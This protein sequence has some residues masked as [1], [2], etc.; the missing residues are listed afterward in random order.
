MAYT[1]TNFIS[2]VE[3]RT[4]LPTNQLTWTEGEILAVADEEA[5]S[6]IIPSILSVREEYYVMTKEYQVTAGQASYRMPPRG[7][8]LIS[9]EIQ[10]RD[11]SGN[12]T[13]LPRIMPEDVE[14]NQQGPVTGFYLKGNYIVLD[15]IPSTTSG[16]LKVDFFIRPGDLVL[17]ASAAVISDINTGTGQVT[18]TTIPNAWA[19]G[20]IF[21]FISYDGGHEYVDIDYTSTDITSNVITFASLPSTLRV[22]DYLALQGQSPLIQLPPE[23]QPAFAQQVAAVLLLSSGQ[24]GGEDGLKR[25][26][27]MIETAEKLITPRVQ[28][29]DTVQTPE[30]WF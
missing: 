30:N 14:T 18:V 29:E 9:R 1:T 15:R 25:A 21:D 5:K 27:K 4:F 22:G 20:N 13:D 2:S 16:T 17:V 8:G 19:T 28:G 12:Y 23:Y 11:S 26:E 24:P 7:V 3:R 6:T 10:I